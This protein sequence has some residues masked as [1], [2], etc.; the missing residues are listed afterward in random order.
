MINKPIKSVKKPG[1]ISNNAAN[2][3]A[4]PEIISYKGISFFITEKIP[5]LNVFKPSYLAYQI[6]NR[7]VEIIKK[8]VVKT[9]IFE[10]IS[11]KR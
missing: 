7:A 5:D 8:I 6:P 2:A 4:A 1:I 9:P 11:I 10:P 3:R